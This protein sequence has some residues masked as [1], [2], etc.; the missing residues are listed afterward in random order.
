MKKIA[1]L[2]VLG[3]LIAAFFSLGLHERL[4]DEGISDTIAQI[5]AFRAENAALVLV[6]F[7]LLYVAVTAASLPGALIL[8][9]IAGALFGLV[10]G[11]ILVSFASTLAPLWHFCRRD[12]FCATRLSN[13]SATV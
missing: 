11:L 3:A 10:T 2:A 9:V 8:T 13:V 5:E 7:F 1:I 6:G 12:M 4:S